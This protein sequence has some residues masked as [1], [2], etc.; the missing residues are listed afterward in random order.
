MAQEVLG[1]FCEE[2]RSYVAARYVAFRKQFQR[3]KNSSAHE[4][5]INEMALKEFDEAWGDPASR[6]GLIP[7]KEAMAYFNRKL[8]EAYGINLTATNIVGAMT[9]N[10]VPHEMR[11]L[12]AEIQRFSRAGASTK[13][14]WGKE[15]G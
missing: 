3:G 10:E 12:I 1:E 5:T 2:K 11:D 14:S 6:L 15:N 9:I 4:A 7:G 8:Q 13:A